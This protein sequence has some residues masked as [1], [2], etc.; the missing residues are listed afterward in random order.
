MI[1]FFT[2]IFK[3]NYEIVYSEECLKYHNLYNLLIAE[4]LFNEQ[5]YQTYKVQ[6]SQQLSVHRVQTSCQGP[7]TPYCPYCRAHCLPSSLVYNYIVLCMLCIQG[8]SVSLYCYV[9]CVLV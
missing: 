4:K 1:N 8:V 5:G 6:L 3:E 7:W 2:C 9:Q